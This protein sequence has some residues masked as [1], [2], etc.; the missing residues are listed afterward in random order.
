MRRD[1]QSRRSWARAI[2]AV[3]LG[4]LVWHGCVGADAPPPSPVRIERPSGLPT[5]QVRP[6]DWELVFRVGGTVDDARLTN[7]VRPAAFDGG[8]YVFDG[9]M[10]QVQRFD[11]AGTLVWV[12]GRE[13]G[14]PGEFRMPRD[15]KVDAAGRA[16][17][18]DPPN[19]RITILD[20]DANHI[21]D[22]VLHSLRDAPDRIVPLPDDQVMLL[23]GAADSPYVRIAGDGTVLARLPSPL[24]GLDGVGS[25]GAQAVPRGDPA[26]GR[27]SVAFMV[28][29]GLF[30]FQG[31]RPRHGHAWFVEEVPWPAMRQQTS[32]TTT[33]TRM[34][35]PTFGAASL[36]VDGDRVLVFF[37]GRTDLNSRVLDLYSASDGSYLESWALP[38]LYNEVDYRGG[39]LYGVYDDPFPGVEAWRLVQTAEG[40][41]NGRRR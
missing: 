36:A 12:F 1:P 11:T 32:G 21:R 37:R 38:R 2:R 39:I 3:L 16:W 33:V 8:L 34:D 19:D 29:D 35:R 31:D 6:V 25:L 9:H 4:P 22:I 15:L 27:W 20:R 26:T 28:G 18:L 41:G 24:A 13:G 23:S 30:S 40:A 5:R 10:K 17:I 14:G 7:P